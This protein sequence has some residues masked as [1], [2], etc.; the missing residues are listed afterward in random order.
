MKSAILGPR[1]ASVGIIE[2][3]L[4]EG[5]SLTNLLAFEKNQFDDPRDQ[6]FT[7][8]LCFGVLRWYSLLRALLTPYLKKPLRKRDRDLEILLLTGLYQLGWMQTPGHAA[9]GETVAVCTALNKSW[10][11]ALVNGVLRNYQ[12]SGM[13]ITDETLCDSV[14]CAHPDW[15]YQR[16]R[17]AWPEQIDEITAANNSQAPMWLRVN[18][19]RGSRD[20]YLSR[21]TAAGI[22]AEVS[23]LAVDALRLS[24]PQPV[25]ELPRFNDGLVSV[26]DGAAQM[27]AELLPMAANHRVLDACAAPGGKTAHLLERQPGIDLTALDISAERSQKIRENLE[28]L[29]LKAQLAVGDAARPENW[30]DGKAFD[31]I[32]L[33]APCSATGVIR[34]HPDIK[35][36]RRSS[37]LDTLVQTQGHLLLQLWPLLRRGGILLYATCSILPAENTELITTFTHCQSDAET[38]TLD[39]DWGRPTVTGR[40]LLPG[41]HH[42][43]GFFYAALHKT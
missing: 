40:Q 12:R 20:D 19:L 4:V 9:V 23:S 29:G 37:D 1:V 14:A 26:Q 24:A 18:R 42:M 15:L 13:P 21:L 17:R 32:L 25:D 38:H 8:A 16:L 22:E 34:R 6:A 31:A 33:D 28:R 35:W 5:R 7:R 2:K 10:A 27:A 39:T 41:E 30:W 3:V 43:D 36:L 11:T